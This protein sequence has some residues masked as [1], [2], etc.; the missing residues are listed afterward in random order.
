MVW[1]KR[2][3][4]HTL[5]LSISFLP[6]E[7]FEHPFNL[8]VHWTIGFS[9][10]FPIEIRLFY[11]CTNDS[12]TPDFFTIQISLNL[13]EFSKFMHFDKWLTDIF[14]PIGMLKTRPIPTKSSLFSARALRGY[15]N[16]NLIVSRKHRVVSLSP[17]VANTTCSW[18][19]YFT[20]ITPL[21]WC[22]NGY[23]GPW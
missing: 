15:A 14:I 16:Y 19:R 5:E 4:K 23:L 11:L 17:I 20:V 18:V 22:A 10:S 13:L 8:S 9:H 12:K 6:L 3:K 2:E 7:I 21:Y 1:R